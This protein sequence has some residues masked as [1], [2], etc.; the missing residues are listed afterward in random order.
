M[1]VTL[2]YTKVITVPQHFLEERMGNKLTWTQTLQVT[3]KLTIF[4]GLSFVGEHFLYRFFYGG[5]FERNRVEW[6]D[7]HTFGY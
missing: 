2:K 1:V 4:L 3:A 5:P 7:G 6:T